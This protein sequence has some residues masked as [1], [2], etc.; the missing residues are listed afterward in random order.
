MG[1]LQFGVIFFLALIF[2]AGAALMP[3]TA[4][5]QIFVTNAT[6][7]PTELG[8]IAEYSTAGASLNVPLVSGLPAFACQW[9]GLSGSDLFVT[10]GNTNAI[11]EYTTSGN[12][13]NS[14]ATLISGL[15]SPTGITASGSDLF[16][17]NG[18]N[19][20]DEYTTSG[21]LVHAF[22][23]SGMNFPEGIAVSQ[24]GSEFN[25]FVANS[26][27]NT[28]GQYT[29]SGTTVVSS[30]P[31]LISGLSGP[32]NVA[33]SGSDLF[34]TDFNNGTVVKYT[35]S[36]TQ[37]GTTPLV[38]GL[39]NPFGIAVAGSNLYVSDFIG[40]TISEYNAMS[41]SPV[42]SF[43][44][45]SGLDE[46]A[47]LVVEP[48]ATSDYYFT[49]ASSSSWSVAGNFNNAHSGGT[50]ETAAPTS[51]NNVFLTADLA[52][53]FTSETLDGSYTINAL[54]FTGGSTSAS[55]AAITLASGSGGTLTLEAGDGFMDSSGN[56]YSAGVGLLVQANS[57]GG[58]ITAPI[59]LGN[60]QTWE[61]DNSS[62]HPLTVSGAIGDGGAGLSLTKTGAGTLILAGPNTYTGPTIISGGTLTVANTNA[63][64]DS[65]VNFSSGVLNFAAGTTTATFANLQG[66]SST[67]N[68]ALET[69]DIPTPL[70]VTLTVGGNNASLVYSGILSG[71][72]SLI[73][74]GTGTLTIGSADYSGN[75]T[76]MGAGTLTIT[77]GTMDSST[78]TILVGNGGASSVASV[79]DVTGGSITAGTLNIATVA[80]STGSTASIT[81]S[82]S[83]AFSAVNV[84]S[85]SN[86]GG[87]LTINTDGTVAL[88][89]AAFGRDSSTTGGPANPTGGLIING[90]SVTATSV[91]ADSSVAGRSSDININGGSLTIGSDTSTNAFE[92]ATG[93]GNGFLTMDG[94]S[95]TY[96]GTDGLLAGVH[97]S[98]T[99]SAVSINGATSVANLTGITLNAANQSSTSTLTVGT[100][101]TLYLGSVGLVAGTGGTVSATLGTATIG[102]TANWSSGTNLPITLSGAA[103][104]QAANASGSPYNITLGGLLSGSGSLT[105]TGLGTL[106]LSASSTYNGATNV[107][108]GT[109]SIPSGVSL[110]TKNVNVTGGVMNLTGTLNNLPAVSATVAGTLNVDNGGNTSGSPFARNFG[111]VTVGAGGLIALTYVNSPTYHSDR[112]ILVVGTEGSTAGVTTFSGGTLD[113]GSNDMIVDG[114][115]T[116]GLLTLTN[117]ARSGLS[118]AGG[119]WTGTGLTTSA[120]ITANNPQSNTGLAIV[121]N[122]T[123]AS[124]LTYGPVGGSPTLQAGTLSGSTLKSTFDGQTVSDTDILVKYTY[125][126]DTNL[127][128]VVNASDYLAIDSAFN[129]NSSVGAGGQLEAGWANGDFNYDG[130]INGDDYTLIDN[131]F[132]S[133]GS[134]SYTVAPAAQPTEM[135][136]PAP[137]PSS[138]AMLIVGAAGMLRRRGR[139]S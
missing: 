116:A 72:G 81:G 44:A 101:A 104:I 131:A 21:T 49:G 78:S 93:V 88:G 50:A 27:N 76:I 120:G 108:A 113:L 38:S 90:G 129:H 111:S 10:N 73:K 114:V 5:G 62:A 89:V 65:A 121:A 59:V 18:N 66:T 42:S 85:S 54:S 8:N 7:T 58:T 52:S 19:T 100:G 124:T 133:Q 137:E 94:G 67:Q 128:G 47:G 91:V 60:S 80:N 125:F 4:Q 24:S 84:A 17:I 127:D 33:V 53:N 107:T 45:P 96:A 15:N 75:T 115:G 130:L 92:L 31:S 102:A 117:A 74:V 106:T 86:T 22:S 98:S 83:A 3:A 69:L 40:N 138:L 35:T 109:L 105:K 119:I 132:N 41:G 14:T 77:G 43:M 71:P 87:S 79:L 118:G 64:L 70:A 48:Q 135:I 61:I 23:V 29:L 12:L 103:T 99:V 110:A 122:D 2:A 56:S 34:I 20:I 97:A 68:L 63:L 123:G 57:A 112:T 28:I 6:S 55:T 36:G 51:A 37:V 13:V 32:Q 39:D 134:A 16:F 26:G 9:I 11:D 25:V 139:Q 1:R 136:A 82:A 46:P 30:T 126:G 95:L